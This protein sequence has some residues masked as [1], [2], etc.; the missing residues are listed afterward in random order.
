MRRNYFYRAYEK[1]SII[2]YLFIV[3]RSAERICDSL[4]NTR[5]KEPLPAE[6]RN[7]IILSNARH[8]QAGVV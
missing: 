2:I 1:D 3:A 8:V 6:N 4:D 5:D 7:I